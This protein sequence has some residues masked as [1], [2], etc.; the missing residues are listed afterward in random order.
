MIPI[1]KIIEAVVAKCNVTYKHGHGL[2]VITELSHLTTSQVS[3]TVYPVICLFQDFEENINDVDELGATLHIIIANVTKPEY[4]A[5]ERYEHNFIPTLYPLL[6]T[7]ITYLK[8]HH[9]VNVVN[10]YK[11]IDRVSWGKKG[12]YSN[13]SNVF[14]DYIDA[15]ELK[16]DIDFINTCN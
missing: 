13:T 11:K 5:P 1:V 10:S 15:I 9:N 7:F 4:T 3:S 8:Q 12:L 2:E 14:N 6:E 16:I